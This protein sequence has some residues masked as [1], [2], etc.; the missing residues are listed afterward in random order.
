MRS[1]ACLVIDVHMIGMG[2]LH[3]QSHF[4]SA[5]LHIPLVFVTTSPD[6]N[7]RAQAVHSGALDVLHKPSGVKSLLREIRS[8]LRVEGGDKRRK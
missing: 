3:L 5:G 2:G 6:A 8:A 4:A 1:T 7:T